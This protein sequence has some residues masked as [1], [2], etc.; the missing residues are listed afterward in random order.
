M[1]T[2]I[3]LLSKKKLKAHLIFPSI[4]NNEYSGDETISVISICVTGNCRGGWQQVE[5]KLK[6]FLML[7][8]RY[9]FERNLPNYSTLP[10]VS[11]LNTLYRR[12][13][14]EVLTVSST[15]VPKINTFNR[16]IWFPTSFGVVWSKLIKHS[17]SASN[18]RSLGLLGQLKLFERAWAA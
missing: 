8:V 11:G 17:C 9:W 7:T 2:T 14:F 18:W 10:I 4:I 12:F 15:F 3:L 16:L 5:K 13:H 6:S 1:F